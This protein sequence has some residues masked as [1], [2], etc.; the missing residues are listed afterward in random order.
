MPQSSDDY[1]KEVEIRDADFQYWNEVGFDALVGIPITLS[2]AVV[3]FILALFKF[4]RRVMIWLG[5]G[6][7]FASALCLLTFIFALMQCDGGKP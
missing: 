1:L 3:F 5:C 7:S 2:I 6:F 4:K